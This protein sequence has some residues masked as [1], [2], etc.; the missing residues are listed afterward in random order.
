MRKTVL[1]S[2]ICLL[3][4]VSLLAAPALAATVTCPSSCSCL[5]PAEAKKGGYPGYCKGEQKVCDH[6][7]QKNEKFCYEKPVT[8]AP[9]L[10]VT[11]YHLV[12][13][14]PTTAAPQKCASGCTCLSSADGKGKGLLYCGGKQVACGDASTPKYCFAL[15]APTTTPT[16][17]LIVSGFHVVTTTP[18]ITP[19]P[20]PV[21]SNG[22][23]NTSPEPSTDIR[24]CEAPCTC[25]APADTDA[26]ATIKRC[27][28]AT[29]PPCGT[30]GKGNYKYCYT[31]ERMDPVNPQPPEKPAEPVNAEPPE[32]MKEEPQAITHI[33]FVDT[34][35]HGIFGSIFG[36]PAT[37]PPTIEKPTGMVFDPSLI[38]PVSSYR[39]A[40]TIHPGA[41]VYIGEEHLNVT[42]ALVEIV[43][44][45]G[46]SP[47]GGPRVPGATR[48]G[49]FASDPYTTAPTKIVDLGVGSR[50]RDLTI[51]PADFVGYGG[52]WYVLRSDGIAPANDHAGLFIVRDPSLDLSVT[53]AGTSVSGAT[54]HAGDQLRFSITKNIGV[55]SSSGTNLR[56]PLTNSVNDGFMDIVV[57]A[58]DG[59]KLSQLDSN[60]TGMV[61]SISL[62]R[63]CWDLPADSPCNLFSTWN[64][65]ATFVNGTAKY[66][67]GTYTVQ[68]ISKLNNM[69]NIYR[70]GGAL[71]EGKTASQRVSFKIA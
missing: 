41:T 38:H 56:E 67:P 43:P 23:G 64:T 71:Y 65:G 28:N 57:T 3:I 58:P 18:T 44:I 59:R 22:L 60:N 8:I 5:L 31:V 62:S 55:V 32:I 1:L 39:V 69:H 53:S 25:L 49:W 52:T 46:V 35:L 14:T 68:V 33:G 37:K 36:P 51:S 10:I 20:P 42:N 45:M 17:S 7:S 40:T 2:C 13:T 61:S 34:I 30:D 50:Y 21:G 4:L 47:A 24:S 9:Q 11:G 27:G 19:V 63:I 16:I 26:P 29:T 15:P 12:T 6:D 70:N 54:V 48:I 66:P